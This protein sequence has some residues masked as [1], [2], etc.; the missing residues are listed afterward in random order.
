MFGQR[1]AVED[2]GWRNGNAVAVNVGIKPVCGGATGGAVKVVES[3][4][5]WA[6][7]NGA[8]VVNSMNRRKA[9]LADGVSV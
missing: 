2:L 7:W 6:V 8:G 4:V 1:R 9:V 5:K 3:A